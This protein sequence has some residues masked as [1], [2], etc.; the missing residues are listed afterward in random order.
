M[1]TLLV[2]ALL[3]VLVGLGVW[4]SPKGEPSVLFFQAEIS[5]EHDTEFQLGMDAD[6]QPQMRGESGDVIAWAEYTAGRAKNADEIAK[7][8]AEWA[9]EEY[10]NVFLPGAEMREMTT[11]D[12]QWFGDGS[13]GSET[14]TQPLWLQSLSSKSASD[15]DR[16]AY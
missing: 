7:Q 4:N 11:G 14:D 5:A 13:K 12:G 15:G 1:K 3:V 8:Q 2:L 9:G 16:H 6:G 10:G